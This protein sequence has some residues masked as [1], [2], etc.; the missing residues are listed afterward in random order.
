LAPVFFMIEA[1][2]GLDRALA[3]AGIGGDILA[4]VA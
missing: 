3:D 1:R 2:W 4:G